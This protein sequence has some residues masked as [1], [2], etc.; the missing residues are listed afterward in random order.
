MYGVPVAA[1]PMSA[2]TCEVR[3]VFICE[4]IED[5]FVGSAEPKT[6]TKPLVEST[7]GERI[8]ASPAVLATAIERTSVKL[9]APTV[10]A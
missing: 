2:T 5:V 7:I 1:G 8:R 9:L 6:Y 4:T 3:L 10:Y